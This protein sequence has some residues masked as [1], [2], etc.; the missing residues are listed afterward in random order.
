MSDSTWI[1]FPADIFHIVSSKVIGGEGGTSG[2]SPMILMLR[3]KA[4]R[5]ASNA[6][7]SRGSCAG[8]EQWGFFDLSPSHAFLYLLCS[9][10][11]EISI[12]IDDTA[13]F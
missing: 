7:I 9:A 11:R 2:I 12:T 4:Y 6:L 8:R 5:K 3:E 13:E 1:F 10:S